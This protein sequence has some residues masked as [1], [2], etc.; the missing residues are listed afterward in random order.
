MSERYPYS[1][2]PYLLPA[3]GLNM[4]QHFV[5]ILAFHTSGFQTGASLAEGQESKLS[6]VND[7]LVTVNCSLT[8]SADSVDTKNISYWLEFQRNDGATFSCQLAKAAVSYRCAFRSSDRFS[9]AERFVITLYSTADRNGTV[10]DPAYMPVAHIKPLTPRNLTV[11][12]VSGGY[13]F[14][15]DNGYENIRPAVFLITYLNYKLSYYRSGHPDTAVEKN[16]YN[17]KSIHIE[18]LESDSEYVAQVCSGPIQM[19]YR[20]EWSVW[21]QAVRWRTDKQKNNTETLVF[22]MAGFLC[23]AAVLCIWLKTRLKMNTY[24]QVPSPA[25]FFQALY[26]NYKGDF[27][28]WLV[29]QGSLG[30][31]L[32]T[33]TLKID[34]LTE[35]R[36][37]DREKAFGPSPFHA[38]PC[39]ALYVNPCSC[40]NSSASEHEQDT[41]LSGS[42]PMPGP[43][44]MHGLPPPDGEG[45]PKAEGLQLWPLYALC[46]DSKGTSHNEQYCTLLGVQNDLVPCAVLKH[47]CGGTRSCKNKPVSDCNPQ[48]GGP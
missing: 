22:G 24:S 21:S 2:L 27:Q 3:T 31:P 10:M 7:Y 41:L 25:P 5:F 37:I 18:T 35:A 6:C 40:F 1:T 20:G 11:R 8:M 23:V 29:S 42:F 33:D 4:I 26:S 45:G 38:T 30:G 14:T 36:A 12:W 43:S 16:I 46:A 9:D 19:H 17:N 15:W 34:T 13:K 48:P 32:Q 28:R 44:Q 39:P 47:T